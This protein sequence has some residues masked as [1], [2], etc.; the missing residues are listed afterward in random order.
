MNTNF[1]KIFIKD[2]I[3]DFEKLNTIEFEDIGY[4]RKGANIIYTDSNKY[5]IVR[6][7]TIYKSPIQKM[8]VIYLHLMNEIINTLKIHTHLS[9]IKFNNAMVEIYNIGYNKMG[10]HSDQSL[11][12]ED[13]SYIAIYSCYSNKCNKKRILVTKNKITNEIQEYILDNNSII[14]FSTNTNKQFLHKIILSQSKCNCGD[15]IHNQW[16]GITFRLSKTF[17]EYKNNI[18]YINNNILTIATNDEKMYF[19]KLKG[20][21]NKQI[22]FLYPPINFSLHPIYFNQDHHFLNLTG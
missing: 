13:N 21:E 2:N 3:I 19:L 11:D 9:D 12:L 16:L 5:P 14:L 1:I 20:Q 17:I 7:T 4:C 18:P 10:Y 15:C 6:T 8:N 22:S